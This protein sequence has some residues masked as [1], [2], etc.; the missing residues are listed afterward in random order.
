MPVR[1]P[2]DII[3]SIDSI[4]LPTIPQTL[5]RFKEMADDENISL[6]EL[7]VFLGQDP[8]LTARVLSIANS[9]AQRGRGESKDL[10]HALATIGTRLIRTLAASLVVQ[11]VFIPECDH[12]DLDL[13]GF[14]GHALRVAEVAR[15]IA[16]EIHFADVGEAHL[17]GL[18]HNVGQLL[19]LGGVGCRYRFLLAASSDESVLRDHEE[20]ELGTNHSEV[21][22]WLVDQWAL[23]SFM[24]DAILFHHAAAAEIVAADTLSQIVWSAHTICHYCAETNPLQQEQNADFASVQS[25]LGIDVATVLTLYRTS[26]LRVARSASGLGISET[27]AGRTI[28]YSSTAHLEL[29]QPPLKNRDNTHAQMAAMVRSMAMMHPLQRLFASFQ[30]EAEM[31]ASMRESAWLLFGPGHCAFL[32][33][34]RQEAVLSGAG[35][36]G[37]PLLLQQI[38]IPLDSDQSIAAAVALGIKPAAATFELESRTAISL[39]DVQIS[40]ILGSDGLVYIPLQ[41]RIRIIG[42]MVFGVNVSHFARLKKNLPLMA[43]FA[44]VAAA[45]LEELHESQEREQAV[46]AHL[47]NSFEL[48]ARTVMHEVGKPL[49]IIKEYLDTVRR[50][51]PDNVTILQEVSTLGEEIDR[52]TQTVG[53]M[54]TVTDDA[55]VAGSGSVDVNTLIE[56]MLERYGD[57]LFTSHG[58]KIEKDLDAGLSAVS[59]DPES[60]KQILFNL[61][62]N[63]SDVTTAGGCFAI[64]THDN[65]NQDGRS[66]IEIRLSDTGPGMPPEVMRHLFHSP[67]PDHNRSGH[68]GLGLSIVA[69]LVEQIEGRITCQSKTGRGTRFSILIPKSGNVLL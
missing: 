33:V 57:S 27:A 38:K 37:Q 42:L 64:S 6:V 49:G 40:R 4:Q 18:L 22:A 54:G 8:A 29:P 53:R 24:A 51:V 21:G 60:I 55:A 31:L 61:W 69:A 41:G 46:T 67:L 36:S 59:C 7:A 14:W 10:A 30:N 63:S 34:S 45:T 50:R 19:L 68:V 20:K 15:A 9:N 52:I 43:S 48:H 13:S 2:Q 28:P 65:I 32:M 1:I 26:S 11:H 62:N 47:R 56:S 5:L 12:D 66:Y 23:S 44:T 39:A 17:A 25:L 58:I 3:D 35:I 16:V